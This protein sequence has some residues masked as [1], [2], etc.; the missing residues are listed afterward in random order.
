MAVAIAP[1]S[2][3][4]L[5][6][7]I[8]DGRYFLVTCPVSW[9]SE[10]EIIPGRAGHIPPHQRKLGRAVSAWFAKHGYAAEPFLVRVRSAL[11]RGKGMAS[12][13]ADIAAAC[14]AAAAAKGHAI[15][16]QEIA[17]L[18]IAIEPS[19]GIFFQGIVAFDHVN[20]AWCEAL[21]DPPPMTL[22]I[23]D[24]GGRIDTVRFNQRGDLLSLNRN[25]EADVRR[26]FCLVKEGLA[27]A[28][29]R[30]IG[31]GA[32][33]SALANQTILEKRGLEAAVACVSQHGAVGINAAHSGTVIGVLFDDKR[34]GGLQDCVRHLQLEQPDWRYL[35]QAK[36][37]AGG[38]FSQ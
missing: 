26:A 23:F 18:A 13:S 11:P 32:T 9:Y 10:V 4:E 25:K 2:C 14:V 19:D 22:A 37:V 21:G 28:N 35:G 6:Q 38:I 29:P 3:G 8:V 24:T 15:T 17:E 27:A 16:P 31:E 7:G 1:G 20:G 33:L 34:L 36:L 5:V 12:S 30:L